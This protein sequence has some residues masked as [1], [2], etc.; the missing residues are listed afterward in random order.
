MLVFP[1]PRQPTIVG[2]ADN[3]DVVVAAKYPEDVQAFALKIVREVNFWVET[4]EFTLAEEKTVP[5][6]IANP[7]RKK[8]L[9]RL[10]Y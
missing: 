8:T 5:V 1:I 3:F 4:P 7:R 2:F 9:R 6:S 10:D